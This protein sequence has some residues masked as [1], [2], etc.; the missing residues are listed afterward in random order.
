MEQGHD[1]L[2]LLKKKYKEIMDKLQRS[3][4]DLDEELEVCMTGSGSSPFMG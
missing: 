4:V 3:G 1:K 2:E